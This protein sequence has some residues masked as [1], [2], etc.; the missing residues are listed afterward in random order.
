VKLQHLVLV[1]KFVAITV[2]LT[3]LWMS[4]GK[5]AYAGVFEQLATPIYDL[6]GLRTIRP[7]GVHERF[8][9]YL[10][11]LVLML[12]TPRLSLLRRTLGIAIG[13]VVL[14]LFH[15]GFAI[16][17][18]WGP[19][20]GGGAMTEQAFQFSFPAYILSD[21]LPFLLWIIIAHKVV[22]EMASKAMSR[23]GPETAAEPAE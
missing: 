13:C 11:F 12:L 16:A 15:V 1:L 18:S 10:P 3:W 9:N 23:V 4:W 6:L 5:Q 22:G 2:P 19:R 14:F 17:T 7:T 20:A 8:I 21:S